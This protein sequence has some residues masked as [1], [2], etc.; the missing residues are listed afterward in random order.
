MAATDALRSDDTSLNFFHDLTGRSGKRLDAR[1]AA[2]ATVSEADATG[3]QLQDAVQWLDLGLC[4]S[5]V[6]GVTH[7]GFVNPTPVQALAIPQ[8][9]AKKDVCVRAVTGSGKTA[10]YLLP[11]LHHLATVTPSG[12]FR[13]CIRSMLIVPTRE[14]ALQC[15]S[16]AKQLSAFCNPPIKIAAVIGGMSA[17]AQETALANGPDLVIATP[18]RICDVY[19]NFDMSSLRGADML[20]AAERPGSNGRSKLHYAAHSQTKSAPTV[21]KSTTN[22]ARD[23]LD[24]TRIEIFIMDE[25]DKLV[26]PELLPQ[27]RDIAQRVIHRRAPVG[28]ASRLL[29]A[30]DDSAAPPQVMM[31]SATLT[32]AVDEFAN[33]FLDAKP[34]NIE[35]GSVALAAQ[36]RQHFIR[37]D[38]L[39][40]QVMK[41]L[42]PEAKADAISDPELQATL[43]KAKTVHLV[44][45]C[46]GAYQ[47]PGTLIFAK[48][49]T[50]V[51]RLCLLFNAIAEKNPELGFL[52]ADELQ[53][54]LPIEHRLASLQRFQRHE[55]RFLFATDVASRGLDLEGCVS[56]VINYDLPPS[57]PAYIHRVGR[58]ARIGKRGTAMSLVHES[59]DAV[60]M[61]GILALSQ[62]RRDESHIGTEVRRR[63][64]S[65]AE[66]ESAAL[67]TA[68]CFDQVREHLHAEEVERKIEEVE[69]RLARNF[70]DSLVP[71]TTRQRALASQ[72][73]RLTMLEEHA[74]AAASS[75][76]EPM[77]NRR[78]RRWSRK[79]E[80]QE[81]ELNAQ[82]ASVSALGVTQRAAK[83]WI[84]SPQEQRKRST[85]VA[86]AYNEDSRKVTA[87]L[88]E[89]IQNLD[90]EHS[91]I[92]QKAIQAKKQVK[93]RKEV[94]SDKVKAERRVHM[95]KEAS[96]VQAG[97]LKK[98]RRKKLAQARRETRKEGAQS[99]KKKQKSSKRQGKNKK[100]H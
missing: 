1:V 78:R 35:I 45:A 66:L 85:E 40:P 11:T 92:N 30:R 62:Q 10:A 93:Q 90:R 17:Q 2:A 52:K 57:L 75:E 20:A 98:L 63:V 7:L 67:Q 15:E 18:G 51:H 14:L 73:Q 68:S 27:V 37:V 50:T 86:Q 69:K 16:A 49:R 19:C 53:G 32:T 99:S 82:I 44:A 26:A 72:R 70:D 33:E 71:L 41:T 48:H 91:R 80:R 55:T 39:P 24:L 58:T 4:K 89:Q 29:A 23:F 95:Q 43:T 31:F 94:A 22:R 65:E 25:C 9:I 34:A 12:A 88:Q 38:P 84:F 36:L 21:A 42:E 81:A 5:L 6:R 47:Q 28:K 96:K 8:A 60:V 59:T 74:K 87:D 3:K 61:R 54:D 76:N 83:Q 79:L 46:C 100:R 56:T 13:R 64:L 77:R 97:A